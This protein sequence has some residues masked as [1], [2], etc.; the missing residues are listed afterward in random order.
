MKKVTLKQ[1][2]VRLGSFALFLFTITS[3]SGLTWLCYRQAQ[4]FAYPHS[5]KIDRFPPDVGIEDWHDVTFTT[6][7]GIELKGWYFLPDENAE[8]Y[9]NGAAILFVHGIAGNRLEFLDEAAILVENGYGALLFDLRNHGES[10]GDVTTMG[11]YE[12]RD[13]QAAF[14]F[15]IEQPEINPDRIAIYG[16][17]MGGAT[18]IRAMARIP[19]AKVLI[20]EAGYTSFS[21]VLD[22]GIRRITSHTGSPFTDLITWFSE[23]E[24][25]VDLSEVRPIDDIRTISPRP[26]LIIHGTDDPVVN[27]DHARQLFEKADEPK[28]LYLVEGGSHGGLLEVAGEEYV[29]RLLGFLEKYL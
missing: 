10:G 2:I 29:E 21:T 23:R 7:D 8:T 1:R 19:E 27:V 20:A 4:A 13:V 22:D 15:L 6:S 24:M 25:D 12:V 9:K 3:V 11:L 16:M 28:E 5:P 17:S 26:V 18:A 14:A